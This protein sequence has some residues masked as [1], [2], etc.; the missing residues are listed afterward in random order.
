MVAISILPS[1]TIGPFLA[2]AD[3]DDAGL[4]RVDDGGEILDP[5]HAQIGDRE[6]AAFIFVGLE[7]L[8]LGLARQFLDLVGDRGQPLGLGREHDG[9]DQARGNGDRDADIGMLVAQ[10]R[11][12]G[13]AGIDV[14]MLHQRHRRRL[15][16]EVI[17]REFV[18]RNFFA[19]ERRPRVRAPRASPSAR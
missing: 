19:F 4:R 3:R 2:R 14:G 7:L 9:R 5:E 11:G 1:S 10:D 8:V 6:T 12:V 17:D 13:P 18:G 15:H 16:H